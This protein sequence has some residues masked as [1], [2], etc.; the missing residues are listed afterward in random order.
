MIDLNSTNE[1]QHRDHATG[2]IFPWY[3]KS[4]LDE[5]ATWDLKDKIVVEFGMGASTLW[6]QKKVAYLT[7]FD[8]NTEWYNA[9]IMRMDSKLGDEHLVNNIQD[10]ENTLIEMYDIAI[11]DIDPVSLRDDCISL[12]L[13]SLKPGGKLI[14]DNWDQPSVWVPS[15]A[16][17]GLLRPY[18]CEIYKQEGHP[19]WQ[20][21][22]FTKPIVLDNINLTEVSLLPNGEHGIAF[23]YNPDSHQ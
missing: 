9:V 11:I 23:N 5:L 20:T 1:W 6:W 2:L 16:T 12:A 22:V 4:F 21:A 10:I 14:I 18:P 13:N 3:V 8:T 15:E 17:R 19:D 7:A